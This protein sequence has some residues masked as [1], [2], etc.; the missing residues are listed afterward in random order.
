[1]PGINLCLHAE[2]SLAQATYNA[3]TILSLSSHQSLGIQIL[4]HDPEHDDFCT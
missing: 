4:L 3:L 2:P 1:M